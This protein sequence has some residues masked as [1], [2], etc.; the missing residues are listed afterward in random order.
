MCSIS[1]TIKSCLCES[2]KLIYNLV[3]TTV[4]IKCSILQSETESHSV[5]SDSTTLWTIQ[6][7]EFARPE[8]EWVAF[9]V[10]S[11]SSQPKD[12]IDPGLLH[13]RRIHHQKEYY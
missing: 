5:M 6:S 7:M 2:I 8:L 3:K 10:S 12:Q 11:G 13:C 4:L 1:E 9:S